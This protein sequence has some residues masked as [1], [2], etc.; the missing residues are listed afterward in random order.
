MEEEKKINVFI[1]TGFLGAGKTTVLNQLLRQFEGERNVV[2]ENE[3]GKVN[4]DAQLI[5]SSYESVYEMTNGCICC[6]L[7]EE[8]YGALSEIAQ[9]KEQ[10]DNIFIETSGVADAGNIATVFKVEHVAQLF[11]LKKLI[12]LTD[13]EN[14][15]DY[16][17]EA[18]EPQRQVVAADLIVLNKAS[19]VNGIYLQS[20]KKKIQSINPYATIVET[21]TGAFDKQ[22]LFEK[23][24]EEKMALPQEITGD[25]THK[26]NNVLHESD[27]V[28]EY[29]ALYH[30]LNTTLFL[31]YN[32][33]F[34]IKGFVRCINS[35]DPNPE[36]K[37]Y[38]VHSTGKTL[39]ITL[40]EKKDF[41]Q[42]QLV[43][44]GKQ[45]KT[46]TVERILR[47]AVYK[48]KVNS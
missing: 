41:T 35:S 26:I 32:Q 25:N 17:N 38:V 37:T 9:K 22:L 31:Y 14:F 15:E 45:L 12:C 33:I 2:I 10:T 20:L 4:I 8:L 23:N 30:V 46:P 44:I 27:E 39:T 21:D 5:D 29:L 13:A 24:S 42:N 28:F 40:V 36:V 19:L 6:S 34:R 48:E 3:F 11:D 43:F 1:L 47:G 18:I 16:I 7:D